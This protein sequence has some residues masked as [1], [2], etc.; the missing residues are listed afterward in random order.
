M[1]RTERAYVT[2]GPVKE[3][4]IDVSTGA[5]TVYMLIVEAQKRVAQLSEALSDALKQQLSS[6][7]IFPPGEKPC[8]KNVLVT[9][10]VIRREA[11]KLVDAIVLLTN[12]IDL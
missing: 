12:R 5:P 3:M 1:K 2:E 7:A 6:G 10:C 8:P 4:D 11:I 9:D